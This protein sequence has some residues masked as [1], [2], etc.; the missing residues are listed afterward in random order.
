MSE[1]YAINQMQ[2]Y[3]LILPVSSFFFKIIYEVF[4][5]FYAGS[6][7]TFKCTFDRFLYVFDMFIHSFKTFQQIRCHLFVS[8]RK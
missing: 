3:P 8:V 2:F 7:E 6:S 4:I 1:F 5:N